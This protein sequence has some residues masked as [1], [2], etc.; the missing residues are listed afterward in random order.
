MPKIIENV[1]E[2][3]LKQ[4]RK[5]LMEQSYK[6]FNIRDIAKKCN[7]AV[8]TV[9]N[10]YPTKEM[11]T[12]EI[13]Q[14]DWNNTVLI[15]ET[16]KEENITFKEKLETIYN[17]IQNFINN[18]IATFYEI[19]EEKGYSDRG[20]HEG[21]HHGFEQLYLAIAELVEVEKQL[22]HVKSNL[23]SEKISYFIVSNMIYLCKK[24]YI[25]F[26]ELFELMNL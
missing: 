2:T 25:T 14:S 13:F 1:K 26:D 21:E 9:Y 18:Y 20:S 8:G 12:R 22:G 23:S 10:Y 19:M 17:S 3:I 11:L 24:G 6:E 15:I 7:I 5:T 4:A 16:L